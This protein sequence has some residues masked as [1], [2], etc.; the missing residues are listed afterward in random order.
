MTVIYL[1]KQWFVLTTETKIMMCTFVYLVHVSQAVTKPKI[2]E[3]KLSYIS[4]FTL[5]RKWRTSNALAL[6]ATIIQVAPDSC[7]I[8][9]S[10]S[11]K[12]CRAFW[13]DI[14]ASTR[15]SL[16]FFRHN[17]F[18]PDFIETCNPV[19]LCIRLSMAHSGRIYWLDEDDLLMAATESWVSSECEPEFAVSMSKILVF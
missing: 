19:S 6:W 5:F 17:T 3:L 7:W 2:T 1:A 4:Y 8:L 9:C 10:Q 14:D 11:R 15:S 18:L 13:E 16:P 12:F